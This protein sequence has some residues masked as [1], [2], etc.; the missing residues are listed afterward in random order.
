MTDVPSRTT[1]QRKLRSSCDGCGAAKLKC[2]RGQPG[3]GR[4]LSLGLVC[5]YGVSRKM[6][7]PPR[8]RLKISRI[9]NTSRT[10]YEQISNGGKSRSDDNGYSSAELFN[11]GS[12]LPPGSFQDSAW[13]AAESY[14]GSW[15]TDVK[16]YDAL[17]GDLFSSSF[18]HYAALD[19]GDDLLSAELQA[20]LVSRPASPEMPE[21]CL[22][23][24]TVPNPVQ[25][26]TDEFQYCNAAS[27]PLLGSATHDCCQEAFDIWGSLSFLDFDKPHPESRSSPDLDPTTPNIG[28][29]LPLDHI[30]NINREANGRL[31]GLLSC[32]CARC[33]HLVFL[34]ASIIS[35]VMILYLHASGCTLEA[36]FNGAGA[37]ATSVTTLCDR[38]TSGS[39]S[40][41]PSPWSR[42]AVST[43]RTGTTG[44]KAATAV[45]R[46]ALAPTQM[47]MGT[48]SIDDQEVQMALKIQL[49]LSEIKRT[50]YLIDSFTSRNSC[51]VD[52][53]TFSSIDS[54]Y[55]SLSSWLRKEHLRVVYIMRARLKEV[56]T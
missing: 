13:V 12:I 16:A 43:I 28:H 4:C 24:A 30:L 41:S 39:T 9:H 15:M 42:I 47:A 53:F 31:Y 38:S 50:E 56:T 25:I 7:K 44:T 35:R 8:D 52:E 32:S 29:R 55:N 14:S 27:I 40:R 1:R 18:P 22:T 5:V 2:D 6:G 21:A 54:L 17:R 33:P 49:L 11:G 20:G 37:D 19:F 10:S 51:G 48:F 34:Y 45:T 36:P 23:P 3:C 26:H 46:L